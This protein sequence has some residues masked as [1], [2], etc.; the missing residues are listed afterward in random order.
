MQRIP[1]WLAWVA[2]LYVSVHAC[3]TV[4]APL[5][6]GLVAAP[7]RL[8]A[9]VEKTVP[10]IALLLPLKSAM[11]AHAAEAVQAGFLTAAGNQTASLPVRIYG[12]ADESKDVTALYQAAVASGARAVVGPLTRS[13]VAALAAS[14]NISVPTLVLNNSEVRSAEKLYF[15]GLS[16][17]AEARQVAQLAHDARLRNAII[18]TAAT[19]LS[20]RLAQAFAEE[21]RAHGGDIVSE[22]PYKDDPAVLSAAQAVEGRMVFLAEGAEK[23]RLIRPYLDPALPVYAT[24]QIFLGNKDVLINYDLKD[25]RFVDMPWMLQPDLPA[26]LAYAHLDAPLDAEMERLYA[27]GIDAF[28]LVQLLLGGNVSHQP[29]A[30][31]TGN[32]QL[33]DT[34]HFQRSAIPALFKQG[35]GLTPQAAAA[36]LIVPKA[37]ASGVP[38]SNPQAQP[39]DEP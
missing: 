32:I 18:I 25:V 34:Q 10:H 20:L 23:A 26:V 1:S 15:F 6:N 17:E 7:S 30:G 39:T 35:L 37:A 12:Y 19:P 22:I 28:R 8:P 16:A 29:I 4:A 9:A 14:S 27:L 2:A 13:A 3:A 21:W 36:L 38:A 11:F 24:S 33:D 31:V 5:A